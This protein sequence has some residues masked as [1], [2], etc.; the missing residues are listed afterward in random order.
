MPGDSVGGA[1][2]LQLVLDH[3]GRI[4]AAVLLCTGAKI[5]NAAGWRERAAKVRCRARR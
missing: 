2:G 5:G 1:V 3:P 4:S